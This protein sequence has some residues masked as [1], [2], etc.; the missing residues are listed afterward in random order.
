MRRAIV[1]SALMGIAAGAS[2]ASVGTETR[3][4]TDTKQGQ[5][6]ENS[7][8][9][10]LR[11]G[12]SKRNV[13]GSDRR[14]AEERAREKRQ[15]DDISA[16]LQGAALFIPML[17]QIEQGQVD[18]GSNPVAELF[19]SCRFFT[20]AQP[21]PV[22]LGAS[23][24]P[25]EV[26]YLAGGNVSMIWGAQNSEVSISAND[27]IT[28]RSSDPA[29]PRARVAG[30]SIWERYY[31]HETAS[32]FRV[33]A[34]RDIARC[35][36]A[37]G[38]TI[39]GAMKNLAQG[40]SFQESKLSEKVVLVRGDLQERAA[41]ALVAA[42]RA[43]SLRKEIEA[44]TLRVTSADCILPTLAG[45]NQGSTEW[46]CGSL[47]VD[48][49]RVMATL[50][51]MTVLGENQF[52]GQRLAFAQVTGQSVTARS[53]NSRSTYASQDATSETGQDVSM[54]KR[55]STTVDRS[56]TTGASGKADTNATPTK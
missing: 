38:L 9:I 25:M 46:Q 7:Q 22:A 10:Q 40:G 14:A 27:K 28:V 53:S 6:I 44:N 47:K 45:L 54:A 29:V 34:A 2:A 55:K 39:A 43:P 24:S 30:A 3:E 23:P 19:Q 17:Q 21:V 35:Y 20:S 42:M 13:T 26:N 5:T 15:T 31:W 18:T 56:T 16:E 49:S 51:G 1:F 4:G 32:L 8:N 12:N 50:G 37:Y 11:K 48:P 36:F 52:M 41:G 33:G